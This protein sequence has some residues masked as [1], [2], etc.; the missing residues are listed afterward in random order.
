MQVKNHIPH[1]GCLAWEKMLKVTTQAYPF[2]QFAFSDD[3]DKEKEE[4]DA[5]NMSASSTPSTSVMFDSDQEIADEEGEV[6]DVEDT[7]NG[8]DSPKAEESEPTNSTM[9]VDKL[10]DRKKTDTREQKLVHPI[11]ISLPLKSES[12]ET[13]PG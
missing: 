13:S 2:V 9:V 5:K 7:V 12:K 6:R 1:G 10:E 11:K 4:Q 3:H 8:S